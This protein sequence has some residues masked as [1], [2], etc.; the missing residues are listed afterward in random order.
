MLV[1]RRLAPRSAGLT[2]NL[3]SNNPFRNRAASPTGP[4]SPASPFAAPA[5]PVSRNPFLDPANKPATPVPD[6]MATA[7]AEP[8]K[9][10]VSPTAEEIFVGAPTAPRVSCFPQS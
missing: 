1:Y 3:S 9:K 8:E 7:V 4:Q 6:A 10:A 2:L 5:R